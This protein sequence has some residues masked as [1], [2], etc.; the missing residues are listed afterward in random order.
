LPETSP[1]HF[2]FFTDVNSLNDS[3]DAFRILMKTHILSEGTVYMQPFPIPLL[4][5]QLALQ[6]KLCFLEAK[7]I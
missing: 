1:L 3:P 4:H 7:L 2:L 5:Q 6:Q